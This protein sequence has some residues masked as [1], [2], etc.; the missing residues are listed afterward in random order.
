MYRNCSGMGWDALGLKDFG[1][2]MRYKQKGTGK[3]PERNNQ[4]DI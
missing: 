1:S 3:M 2:P 4:Y